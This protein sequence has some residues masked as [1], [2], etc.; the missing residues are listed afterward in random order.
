MADS[1]N[2]V[3]LS[4][5]AFRS[6]LNQGTDDGLVKPYEAVK[7]HNVDLTRDMFKSMRIPLKTNSVIANTIIPYYGESSSNKHMIYSRGVILFR[8]NGTMI[9]INATSDVYDYVLYQDGTKRITI[10]TNG[11]DYPSMYDGNEVTYIKNRRVVYNED[12][13]IKGY[14]DSNGNTVTSESSVMTLI[15]KGKFCELHYNRLWLA[16][17]EGEED[18]LYFSKDFDIKDFTIP[19]DEENVNQHGGFIEIP[20]Y[21]GSQIIGMKVVF[22]DL[23]VFKNK[24]AFKIFGTNP[25]NYTI[26]QVF[27]S[28]GAIADKTIATGSNRCFF[29]NYNGIYQYDGT[30]TILISANIQNIIDSINQNYINNSVGVFYNNRYYL[31]IPTGTSTVNNTVIEFNTITGAFMV[32]DVSPVNSFLEFD[33]KLLFASSDGIYEFGKGTTSKPAYWETPNIDFGAKNAK[34]RSNY[35]YFNG[36]GNGSVKFTCVTD[37]GTN[38]S[39]IVPLDNTERIYRKKLKNK[40]RMFKLIIENVSGSNIEIKS[41]EMIIELDED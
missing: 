5:K 12:G 41:P 21:D 14:C 3:K 32:H 11:T 26:V 16:G 28:N 13:S 25:S 23:L 24:T 6:G 7:A 30:N 15:P 22:N 19:T 20:S 1:I 8:E 10:I 38:K 2:E 29:L 31:A 39:I 35:I 33:K 9:K 27:S 4:I 40:G 36:K 17:I 37:A 18:T 34:K